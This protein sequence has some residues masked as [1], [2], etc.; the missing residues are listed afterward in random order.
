MN[1]NDLVDFTDLEFVWAFRF[2][3]SVV[4]NSTNGLRIKTDF[5]ATGSVTNVTFDSIRLEDI[6][7]YGIDIQQDYL[8][9]GPT[10]TPSNGVLVEGIRFRDISGWVVEGAMD[11][12]VLCGNG[13]CSDFEFEEVSVKGGK[14]SSCN[15]PEAG[16]PEA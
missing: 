2:K 16:C 3:D 14:G 11:Y 8:N 12:Y 15:Y 1:G 5:N 7:A 4:T 10:G 9:G 6:K 13:S